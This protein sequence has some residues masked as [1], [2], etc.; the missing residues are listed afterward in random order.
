MGWLSRIL[1]L[2]DTRA[3]T[4]GGR[5]FTVGIVGESK[6]NRDGSSR[7][8]AIKRCND[9]ESIQLRPEPDNAYDGMAIAAYSQRDECL[10]YISR[11]HNRWIGDKLKTGKIVDC[12]IHSIIGGGKGE[13]VGVL[14]R[15]EI[16]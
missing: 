8:K 14:L 2:E 3:P 11:D 1:G 10:G 5:V 4:S 15:I 6:R 13:H 16:I 7:Q 12:R 9:G